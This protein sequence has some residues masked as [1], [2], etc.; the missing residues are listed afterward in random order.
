M[1]KR[2]MACF[3][4]LLHVCL[5]QWQNHKRQPLLDSGSVNMFPRKPTHCGND[6]AL[7]NRGLFGNGVF[8]WIRRIPR[9]SGSEFVVRESPPGRGMGAEA[10]GSSLSK[11][12]L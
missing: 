2:W 8:C 7:N 10:E 9:E 12:V 4:I 1:G 11:A 5:K 6:Y 3:K